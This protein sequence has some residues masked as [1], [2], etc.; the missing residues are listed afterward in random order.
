VRKVLPVVL[1]CLGWVLVGCNSVET[2][3]NDVKKAEDARSAANKEAMEKNPPPPG[4]GPD[5]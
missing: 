1:L 4:E 5:K 3:P 2:N